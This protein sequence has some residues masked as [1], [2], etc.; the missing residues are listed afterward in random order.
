[1]TKQLQRNPEARRALD[2]LARAHSSRVAFGSMAWLHKKGPLLSHEAEGSD[3]D[4]HLA[5]EA[6]QSLSGSG[7]YTM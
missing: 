2:V 4:G 6:T 1:M 7:I 3:A 5:S